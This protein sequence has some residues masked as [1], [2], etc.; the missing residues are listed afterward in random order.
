MLIAPG[1]AVALAL[2]APQQPAPVQKALH[3]VE[4]TDAAGDVGRLNTSSGTEPGFDV[5][6][7]AI[8]SDGAQIT[9]TAT[10]KAPPK[11][12]FASDVMRIYIDTDLNKKT[13]A[14]MFWSKQ[15]GFEYLA[16]LD[17]CIM[18]E[19]DSYVCTGGFTK[20]KVE[21][22]FAVAELGRFGTDPLNPKEVVSPLRAPKVPVKWPVV[23]ASLPY[24]ALGVKPGQI[25]RIIAR[26]SGGPFDATADFP[27]VL[28]TLK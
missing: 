3:A 6:K 10:L 11:P 28:L 9:F 4:W 20:E 15:P 27:E 26:E 18:Y 21:S 14:E 2:A 19:G 12:T 1:V 24:K 8:S 22:Y 16:E 13:G 17:F 25:I 5:V 23:S 7:F